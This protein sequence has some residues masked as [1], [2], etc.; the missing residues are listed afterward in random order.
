VSRRVLALVLLT[1]GCAYYNGLYNA[2]RLVNEAERAE[3]DGRTGEARSLWSQ[4]AV[5]AES[6]VSRHPNS[7]YRDDA[8]L[9]EGRALERTGSCLQAVD[10]LRVAADSSPDVPLQV[11]ASLLLGNCWLQMHQ[12]ES[13]IVDVKPVLD[14]GTPVERSTALLLRGRGLLLLGRDE[15]ALE[16]LTASGTHDATFYRAVALTHLGRPGEAV[17]AL[18]AL[19]DEPYEEGSW[20]PTL[21]SVGA[22]E[23]AGVGQLVDGLADQ[24]TRRIGERLRLW[25]Q[26]GQRHLATGDSAAAERRFVQVRA[27]GPDSA[28]GRSARAY[29]ATFAAERTTS[30]AQVGVLMDSLN[31]ALRQGGDAVRVGG[32]YSTVLSRARDGLDLDGSDLELF[33]AAEDV[34]DSIQNRPLAASLFEQLPELHSGSVLAPKALLALAALRPLAADSLVS[35]MRERYPDSPYTLVLAGQ[36]GE[37]FEALEDSLAQAS[38]EGRRR[39]VREGGPARDRRTGTERRVRNNQ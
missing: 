33:L 17:D 28:E 25:L 34:R 5:K 15:E 22:R 37:A 10:P 19:P 21:D 26:D 1:S 30:W 14:H 3:R 13:T 27:L 9:L 38:R 39:G 36:G 35:V 23:P 32:M 31:A 6:V 7:K 18:A 11:Q 12:P 20:L 24:P 4:A 16:E 2:N 8:L 29:L